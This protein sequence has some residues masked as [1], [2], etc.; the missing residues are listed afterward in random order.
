M[1][2]KTGISLWLTCNVKQEPLYVHLPLGFCVKTIYVKNKR[3]RVE[4]AIWKN[5]FSEFISKNLVE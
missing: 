2:I 4:L 3:L 5:W 1:S